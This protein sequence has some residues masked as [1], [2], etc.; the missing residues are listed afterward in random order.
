MQKNLKNRLRNGW[1]KNVRSGGEEWQLLNYVWIYSWRRSLLK[2]QFRERKFNF[3]LQSSES[4]FS[5]KFPKA[6][7]QRHKWL[8][9]IYNFQQ[10]E[11]KWE[12]WFL[13]LTKYLASLVEKLLYLLCQ[14][15]VNLSQTAKTN[16]PIL[17]LFR[18]WTN[19]LSKETTSQLTRRKLFTV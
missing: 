17:V 2:R 1:E 18:K 4:L 11:N 10:H 19:D 5:A 9:K 14:T 12:F 13:M 16:P 7:S 8:V 6:R 15:S 3:T